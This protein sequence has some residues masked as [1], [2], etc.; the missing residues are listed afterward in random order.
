MRCKLRWV[1]CSSHLHRR[2]S[3]HQNS[4]IGMHPSRNTDWTSHQKLEEIYKQVWLPYYEMLF[5]KDIRPTLNIQTDLIPA[6]LFI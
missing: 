3:E 1:H 2:F 6:K 4:A 5:I